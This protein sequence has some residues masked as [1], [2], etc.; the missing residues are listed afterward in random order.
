MKRFGPYAI[1]AM[2]ICCL[3]AGAKPLTTPD[4]A[5][6]L[7]ISDGKLYRGN[8]LVAEG[9][10]IS[11]TGTGYIFIYVPELGLVTLSPN[12]FPDAVANG[13]FKGSEL[14]FTAGKE[15]FVLIASSA[16]INTN[17]KTAWVKLDR[18]FSLS[19]KAPVV[20][21]GDSPGMPYKWPMYRAHSTTGR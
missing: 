6:S 1:V 21:Y 16:I 11:K 12:Q 19:D 13:S 20:A 5:A 17:Q 7:H 15:R 3:G 2:V 8:D 14:R 18:A 9:F 4:T 10:S